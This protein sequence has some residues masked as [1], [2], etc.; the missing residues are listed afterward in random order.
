MRSPHSLQLRKSLCSSEDP[1]LPKKIHNIIFLKKE[2]VGEN[3]LWIN[4]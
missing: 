3:K 2:T 1:A 4:R